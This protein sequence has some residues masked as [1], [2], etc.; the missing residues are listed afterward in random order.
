MANASAGR[1]KALDKYRGSLGSVS[2][3]QRPLHHPG[4]TIQVIEGFEFKEG[5]AAHN[6][7]NH[8]WKIDSR[9]TSVLEA[10]EPAMFECEGKT[11]KLPGTHPKG[12]ALTQ[13]IKVHPLHAYFALGDVKS[14]IEACEAA[15]GLTP[16]QIVQSLGTQESEGAEVIGLDEGDGDVRE[17]MEKYGDP[18]W[19]NAH[20]KGKVRLVC[21]CG[22]SNRLVKKPKAGDSMPVYAQ[23]QW[24]YLPEIIEAEAAGE[25]D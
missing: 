25:L 1:N 20:V 17:A 5:N 3:P 22:P 23:V 6:K 21:N 4:L 15:R 9:I 14:F 12:T 10:H 13:I 7:G 16:E 19:F 2:G 18:E 11:V 8:W 24:S